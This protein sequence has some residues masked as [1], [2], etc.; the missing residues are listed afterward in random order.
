MTCPF[1]GCPDDKVIDSRPAREGAAI[2]RRRECVRCGKRFTTFEEVEQRTLVVVKK[3]GRREPF[4]IAKV[5]ESMKVACRKRPIPTS[6]LQSAA[7]DVEKKLLENYDMEV[8][9]VAIG[10]AVLEK[11]A[12]IDS[13][14]YVRFASVYQE[15]EEPEEFGEIVKALT[16]RAKRKRD[17]SLLT[18]SQKAQDSQ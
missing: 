15:F 1:C 11:L 18:F 3:D 5:L 10:E 8:P 13:V 4:Q 16:R 14:A 9:S 2:R 17:A 12:E 7:E 6:V